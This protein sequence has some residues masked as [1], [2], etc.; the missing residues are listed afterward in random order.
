MSRRIGLTWGARACGLG[1][2]LWLAA[3]ST[4]SA[5]DFART[6]FGFGVSGVIASYSS[7]E[8]E[9]EDALRSEGIAVSRVQVENTVGVEARATWRFHPRFEADVSGAYLPDAEVFVNGVAFAEQRSWTVSAN[10][11]AYALTG[12]FQPFALVGFGAM[13]TELRGGGRRVSATGFT[14]RIG[15]GLDLF[16]TGNLVVSVDLAYAFATGEIEGLD[17]F[18]FGWGL[19]WRF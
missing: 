1:A 14:P 3:A 7:L 18:T 4:A 16:A 5:E 10:A 8:N 12:R 11:R 13:G 15:G 6:G 17:L 2:L 9:I 19:R